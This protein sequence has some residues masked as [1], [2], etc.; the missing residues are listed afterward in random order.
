MRN[1]QIEIHFNCDKRLFRQLANQLVQ[2]QR[3]FSFLNYFRR[4]ARFY[5][6]LISDS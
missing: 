5:G 3:R 1:K 2:N 6:N 4:V